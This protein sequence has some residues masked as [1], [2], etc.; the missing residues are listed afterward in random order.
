MEV[1]C[2]NQMDETPEFLCTQSLNPAVTVRRRNCGITS[3]FTLNIH[4][5]MF[6]QD[7]CA[8]L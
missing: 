2:L 8:R 7:F 6:M 5:C 3:D 4:M 1:S